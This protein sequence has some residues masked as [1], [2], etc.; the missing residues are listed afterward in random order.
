MGGLAFRAPVLAALFLIVTLATLAMPGSSN[1]VGEFLILLG[2]FKA[3]IVIAIVAFTGVV[4]ASVYSLRL[5]I[6]A[7]H[8]RVG[9]S[10]ESREMSAARRPRAR[11]ARRSRSSRSRST[12]SSRSTSGERRASTRAVAAGAAGGDRRR[13]GSGRRERR[14]DDSPAQ[15]QG[16]SHR[17]G[18]AVAAPRAAGRRDRSCCW[19]GLL[20]SRVVREALVPVLA[21]ARFGAAI[22]LGDL[23]A[24]R[25]R[26]TSSPARCASTS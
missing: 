2:V 6:R 11:A 21:I 9:P 18:G 1:F 19:L 15:V 10:V 8:N 13:A 23:A 4:L 12:R 5:F 20:R 26:R 16:P 24:R 3:K 14:A 25:T 22:G 7:M 17:L